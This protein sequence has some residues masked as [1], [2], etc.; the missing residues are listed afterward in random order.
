MPAKVLL[1]TGLSE[2]FEDAIMPTLLFLP[3]LTPIEESLQVLKPAYLAL[4]AL[5]EARFPKSEDQAAK[6]KFFDRIMRHGVLE[7]LSHARDHFEIVELLLDEMNTIICSMGLHAVKHLKVSRSVDNSLTIYHSHSCIQD[8]IPFSSGVLSDPFGPAHLS[9][10][11]MAL[12]VTKSSIL[13][14][15]P[16]MTEPYHRME[17]VKALTLSWTTINKESSIA[18]RQNDSQISAVKKE[19]KVAA[20]LLIKS[21]KGR[22]DVKAELEPLLQVDPC[23]HNL[24]SI[25]ATDSKTT[26]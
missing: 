20:M 12:K 6:M 18:G 25:N 22:I 14:C 15:W 8:I 24:F 3:T 13:N 19:L 10:L 4:Y 7:G 21:V 2:V 11:L 5:A 17:L 16:R 23:I 1:Q 9:L 26:V